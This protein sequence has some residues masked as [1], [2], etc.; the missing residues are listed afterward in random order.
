MATKW[1]FINFCFLPSQIKDSDLSIRDT[2]AETRLWVWLV[3]TSIAK[4]AATSRL[5]ALLAAIDEIWS[6]YQQALFTEPMTPDRAAE[7]LARS[8]EILEATDRLTRQ[9]EASYVGTGARYVNIAGR[10]RLLS[11]RIGKFFMFRDWADCVAHI[12]A[13]S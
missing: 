2:T 12:S 5:D 7:I 3:L 10:N 6:R 8:K 1:E 13:H 11:Q 9:S 4:V